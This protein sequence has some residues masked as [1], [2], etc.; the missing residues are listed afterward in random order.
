M[1]ITQIKQMA[2]LRRD[3]VPRTITNV[4]LTV[5]ELSRFKC[6]AR[7]CGINF[8]GLVR[9]ALRQLETDISTKP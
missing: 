6:L 1:N 4:H 5:T 3:T 9:A 8:S 2:A 7:T